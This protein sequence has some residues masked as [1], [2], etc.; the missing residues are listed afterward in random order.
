MK[1]SLQGEE[2]EIRL[3]SLIFTVRACNSKQQIWI[4]FFTLAFP[5]TDSNSSWAYWER[6]STIF[7][8]SSSVL[9]S[10]AMIERHICSE[11]GRGMQNL[12]SE[13]SKA[14]VAAL[15]AQAEV[16]V[17]V[18]A[19]VNGLDRSGLSLLLTVCSMRS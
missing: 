6:V 18:G 15:S 14:S 1:K 8:T 17:T 19:K 9:G 2:E 7:L 3:A 10:A 16:E 4:E 13:G 11:S 12:G 5:S